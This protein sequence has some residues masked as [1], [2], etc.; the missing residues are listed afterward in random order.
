M[1]TNLEKSTQETLTS[2]V[3]DF[4]DDLFSWALHKTSDRMIAEDLVQ[5]T[6]FLAFRS[7]DSF[8]GES[9][10]KTWLFKILHHKII[11]HYRKN[12]R[13]LQP[14]FEDAK[15]NK[16]TDELFDPHNNWTANGLEDQWDDEKHL[17]DDPAFNEVMS[18]CMDDLPEQWKHAVLWKYQL[19]KESSEICQEL[20]I[21][22]SNYWQIIHRSKLLLKKCL[23][24][25][26]F[27]E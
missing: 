25:K 17:L 11:D 9:N 14:A 1:K 20:E 13:Q 23:E 24:L 16:A 3:N 7:Y 12:A 18:I 10:P 4:S 8:K 27:T 15:A 2:W 22:P 5:E 21:T 26:W 6:F 19:E